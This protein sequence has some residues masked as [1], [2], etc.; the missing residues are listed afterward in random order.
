[1]AVSRL[2]FRRVRTRGRV[3]LRLARLLLFMAGVL[4]AAG[5]QAALFLLWDAGDPTPASP[6]PSPH[7]GYRSA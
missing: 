5:L 3:R 2:P 4:L 1:M 6:K 7:A